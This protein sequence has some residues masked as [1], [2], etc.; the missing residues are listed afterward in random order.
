[1]ALIYSLLLQEFRNDPTKSVKSVRPFQIP[2]FRR[3]K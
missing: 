2:P 3:M 1:M